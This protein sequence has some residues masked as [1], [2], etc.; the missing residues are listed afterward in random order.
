M[1][2]PQGR[3]TPDAEDALWR[4]SLSGSELARITREGDDLVLVFAVAQV[5]PE[6]VQRFGQGDDTAYLAGVVWRLLGATAVGAEPAPEGLWGRLADSELRV[7]G[8]GR[9][10][11]AFALP[12]TL[13]GP[14]TLSLCTALGTVWTLQ[15]QG[16]EVV[17]P[18]AGVPRP[19]LAC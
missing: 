15:A 10:R 12:G 3:T 2:E 17:L 13:A 14:L 4:M 5:R 16:L 11:V 18:D 9:A 19:S 6:Q 1:H 7:A 8:E